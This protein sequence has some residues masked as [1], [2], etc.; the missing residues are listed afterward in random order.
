[1]ICWSCHKD[2]GLAPHCGD[3]GTPQPADPKSDHFA[4]FGVE[5]RYDVDLA[6]L[7]RRYKE[8]AR[9]LHPDRYAKADPRARRAS[10]QRSVQINDAWKTLRHPVKRAE[11]MLAQMGIEVGGEEGT[12]RRGP[13]G[14][15]ER[16]PVPQEL[17]LEVMELREALSEAKVARDVA[18]VRALAA[19]VEGRRARAMDT[20]AAALG[21]TG[22]R[23]AGAHET[24]A[25]A[26]VAVRYYDRFSEEVALFEEAVLTDAEAAH[27]R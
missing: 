12:R 19:E 16:M 25:R 9:S 20:V 8:L 13:D 23:P 6:E 15:A 24:A 10:L 4:L 18:K 11:Y 2:A 17:L 1:M 5:R 22:E 27:A 26:L 21:G 3:C 7:E 14:R